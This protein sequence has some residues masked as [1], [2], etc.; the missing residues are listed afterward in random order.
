MV[1]AGKLE[2]AFDL[3]GRLHSEKSYD[4]AIR[5]ADRQYKLAD[6]VEKMKKYKFPDDD[7][8]Y[9]E[10][11]ST[12]DFQSSKTF[13]D[14]S[15]GRQSKQISPDSR[16]TEKRTIKLSEPACTENKRHRVK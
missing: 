3:V 4:I 9:D 5:L 13:M 15:E 1:D 8:D 10:N 6:E 16:M 12:D 2:S 11:L 7:D 14:H